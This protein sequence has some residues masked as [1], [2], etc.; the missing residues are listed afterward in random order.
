MQPIVDRSGLTQIVLQNMAS[1]IR[2]FETLSPER[3]DEL[4]GEV[5]RAVDAGEYLFVLPQF[6]VT[7]HA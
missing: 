5:R 2:Q 4:M 3:L 1:Y 6:L 7:G